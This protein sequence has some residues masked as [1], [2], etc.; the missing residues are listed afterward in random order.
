ML[1]LGV[2]AALLVIAVV[3]PGSDTTNE[4][5]SATERVVPNT[6]PPVRTE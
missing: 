5:T 3:P 6:P 1:G 4:P 2:L